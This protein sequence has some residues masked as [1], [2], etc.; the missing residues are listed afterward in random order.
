MPECRPPTGTRSS[1]SSAKA[2]CASSSQPR[3]SAKASIFPTC[4][5]WCSTIS[6]FDF[7]EFN[8]QAGRA[9]RDGAPAQIHLLYGE[10]D[11][12]LNEYL[13]DLDA[14]TLHTLREIYRAMRSLARGGVLR[15]G[16]ADIAG[17]LDLDKVRDRT[18]S[19]AL[20]I[21]GDAGLVDTGEDDE[22]RFVRFLPV[23]AKID[24]RDN[25][26]F[27]EGEAIRESFD[28]FCRLALEAPAES[29]ERIINR[30]IYPST[31]PH[32]R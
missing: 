23:Q 13:I 5:T 26:R 15:G 16:N 19:A 17:K 31:V 6:N 30:P 28:G 8:Q 2:R 14:P 22:G 1:D 32:L 3:R 27:A 18:V 10:S 7:A 12:A 11:R 21:F 29:L 4:A 25:E 20:R 24:M 9:G